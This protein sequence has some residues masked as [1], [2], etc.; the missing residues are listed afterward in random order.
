MWWEKFK[1]EILE[2][3]LYTRSGTEVGVSN[4][5]LELKE[6]D[7]DYFPVLKT[8]GD[9]PEICYKSSSDFG[10]NYPKLNKY[11]FGKLPPNWLIGNYEKIFIGYCTNK[12][13]RKNAASG[14]IITGCQTYLLD[15][16][17][18]DGVI[19]TA[20]REDKPY[21]SAPIIAETKKEILNGSQSK[22]SISPTNLILKDLPGKY[23]SLSYT[24]LPEQIASIRKL[25]MAQHES[26]KNINYIFGT[27][28]G[29]TL[30]FEAV[31]SFLRA[32][33][34]KKTEEIK[35]LSYRDG[36]WPGHMK[37]ELK[38]GRIIKVRKFHANYLIPS[39]ITKY[40]LYQIDY[41]SELADISV[42]DGWAPSYEERTGGWSVIIA[43]TK[44]GLELLNE[45][46]KNNSIYLKEI[47]EEYLMEMHSHGI[48]FKK[49][50]AFIRIQEAKR[51]GISVPDY[52]YEPI[53]IPQNRIRFEKILGIMF[54]IFQSKITIWI[55]EKIPPK[56]IGW[57]FIQ[58]RNIWKK[59][60]K[61]TKK[62]NLNKLKFKINETN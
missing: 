4:G 47:D 31:K 12:E 9:I 38:N 51:K 55:L 57:F 58:A 25:Q 22:Y 56:I 7:G 15:N 32:H 61:G 21:L 19:T 52:G 13:I 8:K 46:E 62:G 17:K 59:R 54:K 18:V 49:R 14:G 45:M 20:M 23:K 5:S 39:H 36:E 1:K 30:S 33:G 41:M 43:R 35:N 11:I 10:I 16:K 50:G 48:D 3:N 29:E 28:Y 37:V 40:S 42:G 60:T 2:T 6:K 26:V 24:G 34:V 44:K 27:F 53:N